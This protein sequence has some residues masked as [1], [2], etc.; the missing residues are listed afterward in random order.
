MPKSQGRSIMIAESQ[1]PCHGTMRA[2]INGKEMISRVVFYPGATSEGYWTSD[3]MIVQDC[4][5]VEVP[6]HNCC[7]AHLLANQ[8]DFLSQRSIL[9][10]AIEES[11]HIFEL[12]P[13]YHCECNPTERYWGTAKK[14]ARQNCK[15]N[16]KSL[17]N[18]IND[19]LDCVSPPGEVPIQIR[20]YFNKSFR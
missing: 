18:N 3:H 2:V 17:N 7:A 12:Y 20:R 8:L 11:G 5:N 1:C 4:K 9:A 15:Y 14:I 16:F 10:E 19:F 13:R 6:D